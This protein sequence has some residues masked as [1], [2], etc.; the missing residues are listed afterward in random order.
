MDESHGNSSG[1][2]E[3][4]EHEVTEKLVLDAKWSTAGDKFCC[5]FIS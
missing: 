3:L 5:F 2:I 4:L 1:L